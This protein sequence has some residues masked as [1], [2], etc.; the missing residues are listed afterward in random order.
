MAN[1]RSGRLL[2]PST[3]ICKRLQQ[4]LLPIRS[5][6]SKFDKTFKTPNPTS[7]L[8][9]AQ[10]TLEDI[11]PSHPGHQAKEFVP[12]LIPFVSSSRRL[13]GPEAGVR[14]VIATPTMVEVR[15]LPVGYVRIVFTSLGLDGFHNS[16]FQ[17]LA[18]IVVTCG[19]LDG[20]L[21]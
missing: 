16:I 3:L 12:P 20:E 2:Y 9:Q 7:W 10:K 8:L 17:K 19:L 1:T 18:G 11:D 14:Q 6:G 15:I 4:H 13:L 21:A 5:P